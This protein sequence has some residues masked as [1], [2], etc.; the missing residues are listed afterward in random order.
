M[1]PAPSSPLAADGA[2]RTG[3]HPVAAGERIALLDVVRGFALFGVLLANLVWWSQYVPLSEER[4]AALPTAGIDQLARLAVSALIDGKFYTL[5]SFLFGLGFAV[6]LQRGND[7]G[8]DAAP[9]YR[10]RLLVLLL[11]G[12]AHNFLL[13]AGDVLHM[14]A[15]LGFLLLLARRLSDRMLLRLGLCC[16][17]LV[18]F[19]CEAVGML[20][21]PDNKE[22]EAAAVERA[23][24]AFTTGS[25]ADILRFH[26]RDYWG[27]YTSG[28]FAPFLTSIV[29]R[30]L[31]G[32]WAGRVRLLHDPAAH[33]QLFRKLLVVGLS[34]AVPCLAILVLRECDVLDPVLPRVARRLVGSACTS[35]SVIALAAAYL[36]A[37]ALRWQRRPGRGLLALLAPVGRMA[38]T[39]YL[40]H[41][42]VYV[43]VL[44]RFGLGLTGKFGSAFCIGLAVAVF[45]LQI[46][47]SS[48][49]L[50]RFRFGPAEWLWRSLTYGRAQPMRLRSG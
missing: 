8:S 26:L 28:F 23:W 16:A 14:Y 27:F 39:N 46:A 34:V 11:I 42:L 20:V 18:P 10:R 40:T 6:Q 50:R 29:G 24:V 17:V 33:E 49:W 1:S 19:L 21:L 38:L 41:S 12:L 7:R 36:A 4:R 32:L 43:L 47:F 9:V 31:L 3:L 35:V 13:W 48:W 45:A 5:F 30:F 22:V 25:P 44:Y 2:G 37:I 15:L